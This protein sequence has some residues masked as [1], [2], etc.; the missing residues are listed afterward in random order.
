VVMAPPGRVITSCDYSGQELMVAACVSNDEVMLQ[1]FKLPEQI[2]I[3]GITY[4]NPYAD[5]H[6]LTTKNC[7]FPQLFENV[8]EHLWV[9]TARNPDLIKLKGDPRS[10]GKRLN[11]GIIYGQTAQA[12]SD[13]QY[14]P[15]KTAEDWIKK[16]KKTYSGFHLWAE[17]IAH[18]GEARGW[19]PTPYDQRIRWVAEANSKGAENSAGRLA[20]NHCIQGT[21]ATMTKM[22]L[23]EITKRIDLDKVYLIATAHDEIVVEHPGRVTLDLDLDKSKIKNNVVT[24]PVWVPDEE[25]LYWA[26]QIQA[27][28]LQAEEEVLQGKLKGRV[29]VAIAPWWSK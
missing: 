14:V 12:I 26:R 29:G 7:C 23:V 11:F 16:H 4:D 10:Y 24:K 19:I 27:I 8:P 2:T 22:A 17:E 13:Q 1:S 9:S 21:S 25:A 6:T 15:L 3:A 20:V 5:L 28:M 18:I